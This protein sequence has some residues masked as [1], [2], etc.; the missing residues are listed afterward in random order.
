M[1]L[2]FCSIYLTEFALKNLF[3]NYFPFFFCNSWT[4]SKIEEVQGCLCKRLVCCQRY[5]VWLVLVFSLAEKISLLRSEVCWEGWGSEQT[6][7]SFLQ[8]WRSHDLLEAL[9]I[10]HS[11]SAKEI[12]LL[13]L[14]KGFRALLFLF[15]PL[16]TS[17]TGRKVPF[18][19]VCASSWP[20]PMGS[21]SYT[22]LTVHEE[23][24]VWK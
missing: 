6:L 14:S 13:V 18:P 10:C 22:P 12:N 15:S 7:P 1:T 17:A 20:H 8:D 4:E 5:K 9:N 16:W 11:G 2:L 3:K 21:S 19:L 23:Y 24:N